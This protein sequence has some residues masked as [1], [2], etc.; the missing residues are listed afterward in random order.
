MFRLT[1]NTWCR[2]DAQ[3][4]ERCYSHEEIDAALAGAGFAETTCYDARDLGMAGQLGEGRVFFVTKKAE[5]RGP[6]RSRRNAEADSLAPDIR[7]L[8]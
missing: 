1:D 7:P 5:S 6:M 8:F 3:V 4:Q 2:S